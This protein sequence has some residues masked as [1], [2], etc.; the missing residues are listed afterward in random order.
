MNK[1]DVDGVL[2]DMGSTLL[3]YETIPWSVLNVNCLDAAYK[4]LE[5]GGYD[6]PPVD[7]FWSVRLR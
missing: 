4:F 7:R 3:E 6:L 5:D 1:F 2:F